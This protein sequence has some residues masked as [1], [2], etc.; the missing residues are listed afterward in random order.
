VLCNN[1]RGKGE[2]AKHAYLRTQLRWL[3]LSRGHHSLD[4]LNKMRF[5]PI[6]ICRRYHRCR[7]S[8]DCSALR[9]PQAQASALHFLANPGG[10]NRWF[11]VADASCQRMLVVWLARLPRDNHGAAGAALILGGALG[12]LYDRI[13]AWACGSDLFWCHCMQSCFSLHS[14]SPV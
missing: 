9:W 11:F 7:S 4:L 13:A 3:A 8:T 2:V 12:N 5:S 1:I 14:Y 10:G 6:P